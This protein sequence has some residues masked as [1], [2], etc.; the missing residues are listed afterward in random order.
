MSSTVSTSESDWPLAGAVGLD[1]PGFDACLVAGST[2]LVVAVSGEID[3]ATC[4]RL[5]LVMQEAIFQGP[6]LV[7]DLRETTFIDAT[8]VGLIIRAHRQ[9]G[10]LKEAVVIRSPRPGVRKVFGLTGVDQLVTIEDP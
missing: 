1:G 5:W 4:G 6:R 9:L 10:Q 8:G 7:L 2:G 3:V